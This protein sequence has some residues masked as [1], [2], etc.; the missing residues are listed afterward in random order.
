MRHQPL[1]ALTQETIDAAKAAFGKWNVYIVLG[2]TINT[3]FADIDLAMIYPEE[4]VSKEFPY[5][6]TLV[7]IFQFHEGLADRQAAEATRVRTDWKYALHLPLAHPGLNITGLADFRQRVR[8]NASHKEKVQHALLRVQEIFPLRPGCLPTGN[9]DEVLQAVNAR[10]DLDLLAATMQEAIQT[11]VATHA[12]WLRTIV[13]PHWYQRYRHLTTLQMPESM[14]NQTALAESIGADGKY[15]LHAIAQA[16][17]PALAHL[18]EIE[19]LRRVWEAQFEEHNGGYTWR[20][21]RHFDGAQN[22]KQSLI[23]GGGLQ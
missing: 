13:P 10:N 18:A 1:P 16:N 19:T 14:I 23:L 4:G 15:L 3:L 2:D 6:Q 12:E 17:Q 9:V 5:Q 20:A 7:L 22:C 21:A 8:A 11:L